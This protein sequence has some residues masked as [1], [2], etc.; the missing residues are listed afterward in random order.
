MD[1]RQAPA[2]VA[3]LG[4][5]LCQLRPHLARRGGGRQPYKAGIAK[6]IGHAQQ[7]AQRVFHL[8]E[9]H[10]GQHREQGGQC[11]AG[12][13]STEAQDDLSGLIGASIVQ[14]RLGAQHEHLQALL[15]GRLQG[16]R[17]LQIN[18]GGIAPHQKTG[19]QAALGRAVAGQ[20]HLLL[21]QVLD[22]VG[23]LAMQETGRFVAAQ[24]DQALVR[25]GR[26]KTFL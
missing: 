4:Q 14:L 24:A 1:F 19:Q 18:G 21:V 8:A 13:Y 26:D 20:A 2:I 7:G 11:R 23:Q 5:V 6:R 9:R 3:A 25:D 17:Q 15:D 10:G 16:A 22:V 12:P